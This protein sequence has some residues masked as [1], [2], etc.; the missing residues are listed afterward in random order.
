MSEGLLWPRQQQENRAGG[1][2]PQIRLFS[3]CRG[4]RNLLILSAPK[5]G[6]IDENIQLTSINQ[7]QKTQ[8]VPLIPSQ[9]IAL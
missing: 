1:L 6:K 7:H 8:S 4:N 2:R 5:T 3:S 9:I